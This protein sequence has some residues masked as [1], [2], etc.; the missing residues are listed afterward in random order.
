MTFK[1]LP[2]F[3]I[4][5]LLVIIL[6]Q[7]QCD[8]PKTPP[9]EIRDTV[10]VYEHIRDTIKG[11]TVYL[12]GKT[13]K[14]TVWLTENKPD[15]TYN[16][17]LKQYTTLGNN[18]FEKRI[19]KSNFS[20]ADYGTITVYDTIRANSLTGNSIVTDLNIPVTTITVEKE[21]PLKTRL[22]YGITLTGTKSL[23]VNGIY[24][25]ILLK[26]KK[27]KIYNFGIGW[28]GEVTYKGGIYWPLT[29]KK[30]R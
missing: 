19:F 6:L 15:S 22:Y 3:I 8:G 26:T 21:A 27:E 2:Y 17:L 5:V 12:K 4:S 16:G 24:G 10:I 1:A 18:H 13:L 29:F 25:D 30:T 7:N 11:E 9:K 23:S 28:S 14:D 20:I